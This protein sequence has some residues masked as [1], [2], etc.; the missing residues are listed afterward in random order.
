MAVSS[1]TIVPVA[2]A[3]AIV[4]PDALDSE[5]VR[6]SSG[7]TAVSPATTT[8]TCCEVT[9]GAKLSVPDAAV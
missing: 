8:P 7:S 4:A 6:V 5:T 1:L 2:D 9:P 3:V